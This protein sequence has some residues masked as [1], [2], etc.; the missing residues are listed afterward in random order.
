MNPEEVKAL[1]EAGFDGAAVAV[2]GGGDRFQ[3]RVISTA[4]DGLMPVKKQ[5]LVYATINEQIQSNTI[6][7]VQIITYTPAEWEKAQKMGIG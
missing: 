6:H 2:E 3:I 7:A 1:V 4:F 5:Q